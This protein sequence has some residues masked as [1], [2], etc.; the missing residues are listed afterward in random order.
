MTSTLKSNQRCYFCWKQFYSLH[1]QAVA[2]YD[3]CFIHIFV[4]LPCRSHDA[5]VFKN[6]PLYRTLPSRLRTILLPTL[7]E[8]YHILADIAFPLSPQV[9]TSIKNPRI[10]DFSHVERK[11]MLHCRIIGIKC[12]GI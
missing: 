10:S 9:M 2:T 7:A 3:M 6:N 5:R 8:T 1:V 12:Q 4:G 11:H